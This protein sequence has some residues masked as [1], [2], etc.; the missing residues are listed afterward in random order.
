MTPA[1]VADVMKPVA[2]P[3]PSRTAKTRHDNASHANQDGKNGP[4]RSVRAS[5]N[6]TEA[7]D[8]FDDDRSA[9][10]R[11]SKPRK[12]KLGK[13]ATTKACPTPS[14]RCP[15]E[16]R[17]D[18]E[19]LP[20]AGPS[21]K[22]MKQDTEEEAATKDEATPP[23]SDAQSIT[24]SAVATNTSQSTPYPTPQP[25]AQA[26]DVPELPSRNNEEEAVVGAQSHREQL[27]AATTSQIAS[28]ALPS[29]Q[30]LTP[31]QI[32]DLTERYEVAKLR[33]EMMEIAR[34]FRA[35][36]LEPPSA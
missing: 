26:R 2:V 7:C 29:F 21:S 4:A 9:R 32:Q 24:N 5:V 18:E 27:Q 35:A 6:Y 33:L 20:Q 10:A 13:A 3:T 28:Q 14:E 25:P 15:G 31:F 22:K 19:V 12:R 17:D 36:G 1:Q 23:A 30:A 11:K 34:Q 16:N 8:E